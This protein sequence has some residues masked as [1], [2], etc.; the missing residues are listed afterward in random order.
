MQNLHML[1]YFLF[2]VILFSVLT[3]KYV[4]QTIR[5]INAT[6][7]QEVLGKPNRLLSF[8]TTR[9]TQKTTP[10]KIVLCHWK[11]SLPSNDWGI[12]KQIHR[13][14]CYTTRTACGTTR[15]TLPLL[16][17]VFIA[18]GTCLPKPLPSNDKRR[19]AYRHTP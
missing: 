10:P 11:V 4:G 7:K 19:Y 17:R 1:G 2:T 13:L 12:H 18:T 6:N 15:P 8:H 3:Y 14:S 5:P 9:T 16:I